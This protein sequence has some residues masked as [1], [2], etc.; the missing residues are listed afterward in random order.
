M[1][2]NPGFLNLVNDAKSRVNEIDIEGGKVLVRRINDTSH[3]R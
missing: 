3:L 1:A 2:H